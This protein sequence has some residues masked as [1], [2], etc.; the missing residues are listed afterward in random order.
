MKEYIYDLIPKDRFITRKELVE[1][2]NLSD[3]AVRD[4][5][6]EIKKEHTI[7]SLSSKKGYKRVAST[8]NLTKEQAEKEIEDIKHCIN[9]INCRKKV[10]NHQLRQYIANLKILQKYIEND[11]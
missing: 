11:T 5:I 8:D 1:L 9:E 3:R 7:I 6:S 10:Y 4:I 2:T